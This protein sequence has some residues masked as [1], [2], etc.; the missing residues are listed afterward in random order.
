MEPL[1][2][3]QQLARAKGVEVRLEVMPIQPT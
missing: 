2:L 1:N 3:A